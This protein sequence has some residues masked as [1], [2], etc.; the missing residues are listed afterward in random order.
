VPRRTGEVNCARYAQDVEPDL[1]LAAACLAQDPAAIAQLEAGP[2]AEARIHLASLG[3]EPHAIDEAVQRGRAKLIVDGALSGYRGRGPLST[4]VRTTIVRLAI[5]DKR[6]VR[7]DVE[8]SELLAAS[9]A[10][11][12]LEYMRTLYAEQLAEAFREAWN[13]LAGHERYI[14][15]LRIFDGMEIDDVARV[16]NIH[17]AT[18][19][20]RTAAA[21]A[22]LI[23]Q[24]RISLRKRLSV[25]DETLDSILRIVTT[26]VRFADVSH[27]P[28]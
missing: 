16:Y 26:S 24:T 2:L 21:R 6:V 11:P 1:A 23:S 3:Y 13:A 20:R 17:R 7:R 8:V 12:E 18:A 25:G 10:D 15:S 27:T 22:S 14:L 9:C 5:D 19:G 28:E 4:F